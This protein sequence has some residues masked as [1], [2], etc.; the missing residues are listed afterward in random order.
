MGVGKAFTP[1]T[2][3]APIVLGSH[4]SL[5]IALDEFFCA[6]CLLNVLSQCF[7][8]RSFAVI[9]ALV[10]LYVR[11]AGFFG[12]IW[13]ASNCAFLACVLP[14]RIKNAEKVVQTNLQE[15]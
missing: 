12:V 4:S 6:F 8:L 9:W 15:R 14:G 1:L 11:F 2:F 10:A 7:V 3:R 13:F 5:L